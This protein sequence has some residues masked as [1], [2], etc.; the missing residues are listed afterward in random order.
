LISLTDL[1]G[2]SAQ[3]RRQLVE[4]GMDQGG[5]TWII[6]ADAHEARV[7][8]ERVRAGELREITSLRM[9][10]GAADRGE[11]P[12]RATVHQRFGSQRHA[13]DPEGPRR[14]DEARFLRRVAGRVAVYAA[15]HE[16]DRLVLMAPPHALG[17]LKKALP[18][19]VRARI[20]VSE[21]HE[22]RE[23]DAEALRRH[24][25]EARGRMPA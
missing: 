13:A 17:A 9:S 23:D 15:R 19:Q 18:P 21:P 2:E 25:R 5:V 10:A 16:F 12:P 7:F 24:L 11:R 8:A 6:T 14:D 3:P 4:V 20:E 1:G 22:R